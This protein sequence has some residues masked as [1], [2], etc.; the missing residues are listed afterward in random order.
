MFANNN[1]TSIV[2]AQL[3]DFIRADHPE[4]VAFIKK[5]YEYLEHQDKAV[6][7]NRNLYDYAD[8]DLTRAD[9]LKYFKE[10]VIP[11]FPEETELSKQK[12]IKSA[13]EFYAKK[14][15]PDS[16]KFLFK[17]LYGQDVDIYL[18]KDDILKASDGKWKLPQ[19]LRIALTDKN[20]IIPSGN[21]NVFVTTANTVNANGFNFVT[22]GVTTNSY[23]K[24]DDQRRKVIFVN[25]A[26][27]YVRT[28]VPFINANSE[29]T[30]IFNS[31]SVFRV[32]LNEY[33]SLDF[34]LLERRLGVGETS[35]TTCVIESAV[36]TVDKDTGR[37]LVEL[38]VS[39]V[40]KP[41]ATN[42]NIIVEYVENGTTKT[43]KS[44]IIS[45]IS[46]IY[47]TR[48]RSGVI[49]NG[50]NYEI[51][52]PVV[53][54]G[55]LN[56]ESPDIVNAV[57]SVKD[58]TVGDL[59][60]VTLVKGG[61]FFRDSPNSLVNVE[62]TTGI[63]ANVLID[64]IWDTEAKSELFT[65]NTDSIFYKRNI[66]LNDS[67]TGYSF[68]NVATDINF[69]TGAG[70]TVSA[71]NL[72][73]TTYNP[74]SINDYYQSFVL[75]IIGG[76]GAAATP[77]SAVI[78]A[79]NGTTKIATLQ[80]PLATAPS[81]TSQIRLYA[82]AN[83]QIGR[84]LSFETMRLGEIRFVTLPE[85]G[86]FFAEP[87]TFDA[88]SVYESDYSADA[89]FYLI[90]SGQF[91]EYN[92]VAKTIK[93]NQNNPAYSTANGYYTGARLFVDVG[94][95]SHY[96]N[97]IDYVVTDAN[98]P[99]M[100]KT[101][102]LDRAFE[103]NIDAVSILNM[104]L[105]MDFRPDVRGTGKI[106][107]IEVVNQGSN[108]SAT[109][110]VQF[111]GTGYG[112]AATLT[113]Q[114][115]KI[116]KVTI[117]N[118][119]EGYFK[120]PQI[121]IK[122]ASGGPS[123]GSGATFNV[124]T[125]SDGELMTATVNDIGAIKTFNLINRGF[126]YES[127]PKV[128]LK[129]IDI[130]LQGLLP[131]AVILAGDTVWQGGVTNAGATFSGTIDGIHRDTSNTIIRVFDY[132]GS[133]TAPG[134]LRINTT[135]QN[136]VTTLSTATESISYKGI[137]PAIPRA[138]PYQYGDGKA[139]AAAEFLSGL[140]KYDGFYLN[141]DGHISSDKKLQNKD[142][143]HNFSYE[144]Q[145]EVPL[146]EYKETMYRAVHPAGMHLLSK[147]LITG[148][149]YER[150]SI[151]TS[152]VFTVNTNASTN[153]NTSFASNI[154]YGNSSS[155]T[156]TANVGD[157]LIINS[158]A[159]SEGRKY[160]RII[161]QIVDNDILRIESPVG[162]IGDGRLRVTNGSAVATIYDNTN[163]VASTLAVNDN[164]RFNVATTQF[165]RT[166]L[167]INQNNLTFN[168]AV[169]ANGNVVY[170]R[171]P[172]FNVVDYDIISFRGAG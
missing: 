69:T 82:N 86:S 42:E 113:V 9:L 135:S 130:A 90:P 149:I 77:N 167:Q 120:P 154:V 94:K 70:H 14:G 79:Y 13:R 140:I 61:Y 139:K 17:I 112:A 168:S 16:F 33:D 93:L 62:S 74:S 41:F 132:N 38:Y 150:V 125:L 172:A 148:D 114:S 163:P 147:Y 35:K 26:G 7:T 81:G 117:T 111:I 84:A 169:T 10:K 46:N 22:A 105:L 53:I 56:K 144:I 25:T 131:D 49:Q 59:E 137:N 12:V 54:F 166:I 98:L 171:L 92:K 138:Y 88:I 116:T 87:P 78:S 5:Y 107:A 141:T 50:R 48:N 64:A 165:D 119:G 102:Y 52:D 104:N 162:G 68:E 63:G 153:A 23:I 20:T 122:N 73:S 2:E 32:E 151:A 21:V 134:T 28:E 83:T 51:G 60:Y 157:I 145:S 136:V 36:R 129:I 161:T 24:I 143:Y 65:F 30:Q 76:A 31:E 127:T 142:Y 43:F 72:Y 106:G 19:A 95:T 11:D 97:I 124:Y 6:Y 18:P 29:P 55:G 126:D 37:E 108:Y 3:P 85:R 1:I 133:I 66:L 170:T 115:G 103:S 15:T 39:N 159:T 27:D 118:R 8:V 109:D 152:N 45:L 34:N 121:I 123:S 80:T 40:K 57:A 75:K 128:S 155:W 160:S 101:L 96:A 91:K 158:N 44:K 47:L 67:I 99:T 146:S 71:V 164:I 89:G 58:I 100:T 156:T 4:F 110:T